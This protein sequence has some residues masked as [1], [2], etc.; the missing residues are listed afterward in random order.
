M[1]VEVLL[2][3]QRALWKQVT[4]D[5]RA[6]AVSHEGTPDSGSITA[7]FLYAGD[8][9]DVRLECVS[10]AEAYCAA[11]FTSGVTVDFQAVP[12]AISLDLL[13]DEDYVFMRWEAED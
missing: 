12:N 2:S 5:L 4:P 13:P 1:R 3:M 8:I 6:V 10:L 9:D 11:D 7:R